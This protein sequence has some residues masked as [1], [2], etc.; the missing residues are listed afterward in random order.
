MTQPVR[1]EGATLTYPGATIPAVNQ[2]DLAIDEGEF[3]VLVG[4]SGC[5]KSTCLRML[6]GLEAV[7]AGSIH[8]GA[9]D[10]TNVAAKDRDIAMVFQNY[11][12][13]P[14]MS[15][16]ENM[17]FA[18]RI[19]KA[20]RAEIDRRVREAAALLDL[21][22]YLDRK[23]KAL[24][25][26]QRQRVAMGR[27]IVRE[28]Q[29]FLMDEPLSNLDAKLRVQTRTQIAALQKRLGTTTVYVTHDQVEA[30]TMGHRVAVLKDGLLQQVDTPRALYDT[31]V[32]RFVATFIGSPAMNI[33]QVPIV[34]GGVDLA[35][36]HVPVPREVL[37]RASSGEVLLGVRPEAMR[38]AAEGAPMTVTLVEELGSDTYVYGT[39]ARSDGSLDDVVARPWGIASP[40]VGATVHVAPQ[41]VYLFDGAGAQVRL[42]A[43]G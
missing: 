15:V 34:D 28:P 26:G 12:L 18:L 43:G 35:G 42:A 8:I 6:A 39:L 31:P 24:S 25:G 29:V 37:S 14:H 23:P 19:Q 33:F 40:A 21:T 16:A 32:N 5:G 4:P 10:V 30:M 13:Y 9:R 7:T 27:A 1:F 17:S 41:D 11:A 22:D 20:P 3:L 2:L 38:F 36:W